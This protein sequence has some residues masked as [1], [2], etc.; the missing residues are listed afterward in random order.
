[1]DHPKCH[2]TLRITQL[3]VPNWTNRQA[4]GARWKSDSPPAALP[5]TNPYPPPSP[6]GQMK[7]KQ[8]GKR[9]RERGPTISTNGAMLHLG[10]FGDQERPEGHRRDTHTASRTGTQTDVAQARPLSDRGLTVSEPAVNMIRQSADASNPL[11]G[12]RGREV[13]NITHLDTIQT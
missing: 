6:G 12:Q 8:A 3:Q 9:K 4:T 13:I 2:P 1:M 7:Q 11:P 5:E 10:P